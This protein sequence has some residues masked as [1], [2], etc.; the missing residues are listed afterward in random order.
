[1]HSYLWRKLPIAL[2]LVT[3]QAAHASADPVI[4]NGPMISFERGSI[5]MDEDAWMLEENQDRITDNVWITRGATK[6]IFNA[7]V[8]GFPDG[9]PNPGPAGTAWAI[10]STADDLSMLPFGTWLDAV[11]SNP[12]GSVGVNYVVHLIED[13]IYLDLKFTEWGQRTSGGS[14][15]YVR[16]TAVP[17]PTSVALLAVGAASLGWRRRR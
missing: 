16:S 8:E 11:S 14:F 12:P 15:S 5:I 4:W 13:D 6:G 9:V 10:G 1:M 7:R 2:L 17:E 3:L